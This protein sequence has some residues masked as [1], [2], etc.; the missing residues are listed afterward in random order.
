MRMRLFTVLLAAPVWLMTGP[1]PAQTPGEAPLKLAW[2]MDCRPGQDCFFQNYFD[3]DPGP[4]VKDYRCGTM[5]Y[6]GHD[7]VDIRL[8]DLATM[9]RG[10]TVMAAAD[11]RVR[12]TRDGEPDISNRDPAKP[13]VTGRD[14]GNAV[15]MLHPGGWETTY[16]H[17][18]RGSVRVKP[19]ETVKAGQPIGQVGLSGNTEFPHLHV[20]VRKEGVRVDPFAYGAAGGA[21]GA[22]G[23]SL[24]AP[25]PR[26]SLAYRSPQVINAGFAGGPIDQS[27]LDEAQVTP[28]TRQSALVAYVRAIGLD[29]GDVQALNITGPDG[30]AIATTTSPPL[31]RAKAQ[32]LMFVG[33][34]RPPAGGWKAGTY[35]AGY[36]VRRGGRLVLQHG[37]S[38]TLR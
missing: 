30:A 22:A 11:G 15:I 33:D 36:A 12:A 26:G 16:C 38:F 37:W 24:W 18:K 31:D 14:C 32:W 25:P 4:G 23:A 5:T 20:G 13:K 21:C 29:G 1:A 9:R 27:G 7:A 17:M 35:K 19:G 8:P 10:V 2:P 3:R 34:R 28:L 6:E